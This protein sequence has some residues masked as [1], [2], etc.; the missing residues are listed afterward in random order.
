MGSFP[1]ENGL[2]RTRAWHYFKNFMYKYVPTRHPSINFFDS[3]AIR[4]QICECIYHFCK[5]FTKPISKAEPE[6]GLKIFNT[7]LLDAALTSSHFILL[8][9]FRGYCFW[10]KHEF[11][12]TRYDR[13]WC[14]VFI[15]MQK[16]RN[17]ITWFYIRESKK[18]FV[19]ECAVICSER[20][21]IRMH[22]LTYFNIRCGNLNRWE[23]DVLDEM[24]VGQPDILMKSRTTIDTEGYIF[25]WTSG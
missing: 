12:H 1:L 19:R 7:K 3:P 22:V 17:M 2:S 20:K 8:H 5:R 9:Y 4:K 6:T 14:F 25:S 21:F 24:K 11:W 18:W 16:R 10:V 15:F 23:M 13:C